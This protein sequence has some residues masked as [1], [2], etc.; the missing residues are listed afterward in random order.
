ML[1]TCSLIGIGLDG[2]AKKF[3]VTGKRKE[4]K[5][6]GH[7][8]QS[9]HRCSISHWQVRSDPRTIQ[10]KHLHN[11][12]KRERDEKREGRKTRRRRKK[13]EGKEKRKDAKVKRGKVPSSAARVLRGML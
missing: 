7:H 3:K 8:T 2:S 9:E 1:I 11:V 5:M 6:R 13:A 4:K 10:T 12:I